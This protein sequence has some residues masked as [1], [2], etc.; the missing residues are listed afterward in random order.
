MVGSHLDVTRLRDAEQQVQENQVQLLAAHRIQQRLLPQSA[1]RVPGWDIAGVCFAAEYAAGDYF[2][3]LTFP[4]GTLG[5]VIADVRGHG[6][7]PA[8]L[9]ATASAYIRSF[10]GLELPLTQMLNQTNKML[11]QQMEEDQFITLLVCRLDPATRTLTY[12]NAGHPEG[13]I[14]GVSGAVTATL[15]NGGLPLGIVPDTLYPESR[16]IKLAPGDTVLL[17]TDGLLETRAPAGELLG[18][19][20]VIDLVRAHHDRSTGGLIQL[21]R[22]EVDQFSGCEALK[23]DVTIVV[24]KMQA[25]L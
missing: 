13:Y 3:F 22:D 19:P 24:A 6:V 8:L 5:L 25:T 12:V 14:I 9:M 10:A 11:C 18:T 1:P 21:L 15:G 7:G 2:D 4:D 20:R 17:L 16:T 23:D